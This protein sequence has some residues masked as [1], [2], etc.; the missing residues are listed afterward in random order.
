ME[1]ITTLAIQIT[2][3]TIIIALIFLALG[4]FIGN[5]LPITGNLVGSSQIP[6]SG[7]GQQQGPTVLQISNPFDDDVVIGN[8]DAPVV[9]IEFS[10]FQ[11]PFCRRF[12][13]QT[14]S[15]LESEYINTGKVAFV[16]RDFPL[17]SIHPAALPS[18]I[19]TECAR[20]QGKWREAHNQIF[21]E[22]NKLGSGTVDYS[23]SD[24]KTWLAQIPGIDSVKLNSCID[25]NKYQNEVEK[26][27]QDGVN[28]GVTGTPTFFIGNSQKG[29]VAVV[30]AQP[31]SV[32]KSA[33][34]QYLS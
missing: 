16:Y 27:F 12:Y 31:Y 25:S 7:S 23:I 28:F 29:Y 22:Q 34:D 6:N 32:L 21:D 8:K 1:K 2:K 24:V 13:T 17:T 5:T 26:D 15:Q 11:C 10:D 4:Y 18:A 20:E 14:L 30:G 9:V 33:I 3:S 19:A